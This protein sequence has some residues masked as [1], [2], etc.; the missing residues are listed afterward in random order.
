MLFPRFRSKERDVRSDVERLTSIQNSI[1]KVIG[2][3]EHELV[4]LTARIEDAR[5][6]AA[7]LYGDMIEGE[8]DDSARDAAILA[9]AERILVRGDRRI[10]EIH[11]NL[12]FLNDVRQRM[13]TE[14]DRLQAY[15]AEG[16]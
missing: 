6:R 12:A 1:S 2:E 10:E 9:D 5:S 16:E 13:L 14:A 11:H 4:G 3:I 8:T 7:F 15:A